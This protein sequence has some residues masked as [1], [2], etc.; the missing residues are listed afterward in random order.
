MSDVSFDISI[1]LYKVNIN[2]QQY[3]HFLRFIFIQVALVEHIICVSCTRHCESTHH[4]TVVLA[5]C[6]C[7]DVFDSLQPRG[8]SPPSSSVHGILQARIPEWVAICFS[9]GYSQHRDQMCISCVGRSILYYC[10]SR[11]APHH[12]MLITKN[13]VSIRHHTVDLFTPFA[14]LSTPW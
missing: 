1:I 6:A 4:S 7:S 10:A 3:Q 9:R 13:L 2:R 12:R 5:E 14:L 8:L 11:E